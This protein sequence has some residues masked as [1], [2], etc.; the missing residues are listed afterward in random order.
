MRRERYKTFTRQLSTT[1]LLF[2]IT[3]NLQ[4]FACGRLECNG[5]ASI[6][7]CLADGD[8][9]LMESQTTTKLIAARPVHALSYKSNQ[10]PPICD[11]IQYSSCIGRQNNVEQRSCGNFNYC[12]HNPNK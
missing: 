6:G 10:K 2:L 12:K 7:E 9:F 8:E 11:E 5:T 1:L 4:K 3:I